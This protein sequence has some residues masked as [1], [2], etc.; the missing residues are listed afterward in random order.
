[1]HVRKMDRLTVRRERKVSSW[2]MDGWHLHQR[3][4]E[5][6]YCTL[7]V[8]MFVPFI[9]HNYLLPDMDREIEAPFHRHRRHRPR[10]P[11]DR[12]VCLELQ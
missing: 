8:V 11:V 4:K 3:N 9:A 7:L 12:D 2:F 10:L 6:T 5:S 1:M